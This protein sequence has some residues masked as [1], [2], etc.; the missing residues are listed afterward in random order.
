MFHKTD[1]H[2]NDYGGFVAYEAIMNTLSV[3]FPE[4]TKSSISDYIID[5]TIVDGF[6]LTNMM[7]IYD[8]IFE[9]KINVQTGC[10]KKKQKSRKA[11][12]SRISKF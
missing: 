9:N 10:H 12:I 2:W 4:L 6:K 8:G 5:S 7:G 1:N 11:K 3:D